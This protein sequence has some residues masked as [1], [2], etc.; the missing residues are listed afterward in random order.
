MK[1]FPLQV[2]LSLRAHRVEQARQT[3]LRRREEAQRCRDACVRVEG[4]LIALQFERGRQRA[5]LLEPPPDGLSPAQAFA[6]REAHIAHLETLADIVRQ[7]LFA[8]QEQ[9]RQAELAVEEARAAFFRAQARLDAL[10]KRKDLWRS[11]QCRLA[12]RA[13]ESASA[14]LPPRAAVARG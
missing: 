6:Q 14:D 11:E 5:R 12:A 9:L 2:L 3:L 7:R 13:E 8:A 10:E 4:E 1:R